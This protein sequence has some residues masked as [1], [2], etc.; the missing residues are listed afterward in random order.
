MRSKKVFE[1]LWGVA[2]NAE[3]SDEGNLVLNS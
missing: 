2:V 1:I 3:V